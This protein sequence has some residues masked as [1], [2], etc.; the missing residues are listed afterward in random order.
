MACPTLLL[1]SRDLALRKAC[2][3]VIDNIPS[4]RLLVTD[5]IPEAETF[6]GQ[7]GIVLGIVHLADPPDADAV[8]RWLRRTALTNRPLATL[9]FGEQPNEEQR[10]RLV[11]QGAA[12]YL[13]RPLDRN[14][15][16]HFIHTLTARIC[17]PVDGRDGWGEGR[18][19][20]R[21]LARCPWALDAQAEPGPDMEHLLAQ[22]Q[23]VAPQLTTVLLTGETGTGKTRLARHIHDLSPRRQEPFLV[24]NCGALAANLV[25]SEMFGH[26]KG[27][28]TSADRDHAGKFTDAGL[29]TLLLDEIDAL[30]LPLQPKLLRAVDERFFEPVGSNKP[31]PFRARL[32][33]AS[34]QDLD[35]AV[36]AGR[37]RSD[38]FYRLNVVAFQLP[39]LRDRRGEIP[40]LAVTFL[41]EMA[42]RNERPFY[43][44]TR[45]AL[46]AL[47]AYDWPG[48]V[49]QLR[50]L[51][52]RVVALGPGPEI[53]Y[54]DLPPEIRFAARRKATETPCEGGWRVPGRALSLHQARE[55]TEVV[56]IT[57]AL[58]RHGNNRLRA[59]RELGISRRTLY[60]KLHRYGLMKGLDVPHAE[61]LA[62][63]LLREGLFEHENGRA[64]HTP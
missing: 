32:I 60:K 52:E 54:E 56:R 7:N 45:E 15:L 55:Q 63:G 37:F 41:H 57:E 12:G 1:V 5:S 59:A 19:A 22:V 16:G 35:E 8:I 27:A 20:E 25:E 39:P 58:R 46:D 51:I 49:R 42:T 36:K 4:L 3:E 31:L 28:F 44:I 23:V 24:L 47:E 50:N 10:R 33:A 61:V 53:R 9:V 26:V 64:R 21:S 38:L 14:R 62:D 48:N 11:H 34:N 43:G 18:G 30:P 2:Q 13:S 17:P 29:G 40:S 6:L